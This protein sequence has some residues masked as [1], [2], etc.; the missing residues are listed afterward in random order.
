MLTSDTPDL[1]IPGAGLITET[2]LARPPI[3]ERAGDLVSKRLKGEDYYRPHRKDKDE[4]SPA[5]WWR[6]LSMGILRRFLVLA[7]LYERGLR[8]ALDLSL[9][10]REI[11]IETL[12]QDLAGF[13]ILQVSD[14]HLPRR[15]PQ[16]AAKVAA[17]LDGVE[18]DLCVL[19][20]DYRWGYYGSLDHVTAQLHQILSGVKSRYGTVACLGNHDIMAVGEALESAKIPVLFNEGTPIIQGNATLW[21][22]GIDD[23]YAYGCDRLDLAVQDA[24]P[25][26][27]ILLLSHTP[28]RIKKA[29]KA[30]VSLYLTGHTHGGQIRLPLVGALSKNAA[31]TQEQAMGLWR[32][33]NMH[34]YT[35]TGLGTTDLPVRFN[36]QPEAVI[37]TLQGT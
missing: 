19:T 23:P 16:F 11:I 18:V 25:D 24:P 9:S 27:F 34:G 30:G 31:C 12:P 13:R 5:I 14:L 10:K 28:D 29:E 32:H 7:G 6:G 17:L 4:M 26:A 36:C 1:P 33:G 8:N 20:G 35:T 2:L 37:L 15:F 22:C 21:V 3:L